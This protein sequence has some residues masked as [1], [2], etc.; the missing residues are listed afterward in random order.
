MESKQLLA[1]EVKSDQEIYDILSSRKLEDWII[2][3]SMIVT[4]AYLSD[5]RE[6]QNSGYEF[7][8]SYLKE[9]ERV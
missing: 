2:I 5:I 6:L 3:G 7:T 9:G 8:C 1:L 4:Y